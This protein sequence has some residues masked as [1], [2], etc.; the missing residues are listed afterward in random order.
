MNRTSAVVPSSHGNLFVTEWNARQQLRPVKQ[1][2][3][4]IM[5][6]SALKLVLAIGMKLK[7]L[8]GR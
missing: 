7:R 8:E 6:N 1:N 4:K 3:A 5:A 2:V